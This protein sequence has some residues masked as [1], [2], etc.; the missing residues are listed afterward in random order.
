MA[1]CRAPRVRIEKGDQGTY[2]PVE[3]KVNAYHRSG[4]ST[5]SSSSIELLWSTYVALGKEQ[6]LLQSIYSTRLQPFL[7]LV[8][9]PSQTL[10]KR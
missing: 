2:S 6:R 5:P 1:A 9:C 4:K 7:L 3:K 10:D 8:T